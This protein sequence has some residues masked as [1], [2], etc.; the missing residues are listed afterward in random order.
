LSLTERNEISR[1][2]KYYF[3]SVRPTAPENFVSSVNGTFY[4]IV[5]DFHLIET[6]I[7]TR[8]LLVNA[9]IVFHWTDDRLVL[10]ELFDDFELPKEFEPW[11]PRYQR[12]SAMNAEKQKG[13][14]FIVIYFTIIHIPKKNHWDFME[15]ANEDHAVSPYDYVVETAPLTIRPN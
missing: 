3:N 5:V 12:E 6:H 13:G 11:L 8:S 15:H 10:R 1:K 4:R 9:I 2:F 14:S 7:R